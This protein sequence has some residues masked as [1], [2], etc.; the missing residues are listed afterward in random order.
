MTIKMKINVVTRIHKENKYYIRLRKILSS[1]S[2]NLIVQIYM[3]STSPT[4]V[5]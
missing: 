2:C 1:T 5:L 3:I 4:I